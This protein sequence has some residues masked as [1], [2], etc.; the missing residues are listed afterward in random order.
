VREYP[1]RDV[2]RPIAA[3]LL[4]LVVVLAEPTLAPRLPRPL[5]YLGDAS[6]S[7]YLF[8]PLVAPAVPV[9]LA[10]IGLSYVSLSLVLCVVAAVI[11]SA[12]IYRFLERPITK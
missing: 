4:V 2:L 7:L 12:L 5:T 9:A 8:H 11:A 3:I 10:V 6:Y 1:W